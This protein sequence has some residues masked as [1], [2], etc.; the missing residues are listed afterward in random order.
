MNRFLK[1]D[2]TGNW[3]TVPPVPADKVVNINCH[4]FVLY[5]IG[6]ISYEIMI[7]DPKNKRGNDFTFGDEALSISNIPFTPIKDLE[8]L[9]LLAEKSCD[10]GKSYVGQIRD[11]QTG[12]AAHSFIVERDLNGKYTCNEKRGFKHSFSVHDL[13]T[14]LNFVNKDGEKSNQNQNWRFVP[15]KVDRMPN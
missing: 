13:D 11:A 2:Q 5:V 12:E 10:M 3:N 7:S 6:R 9:H 4:K 8:S 14:I 15:M 1:K